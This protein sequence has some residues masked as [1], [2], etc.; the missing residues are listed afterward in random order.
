[1]KKMGSKIQVGGGKGTLE[2]GYLSHTLDGNMGKMFDIPLFGG[3]KA[4]VLNII[5]EKLA[6]G[7]KKYWVA[8]VNPEFVM[9]A[10]K[11]QKFGEILKQTSLNVVDGVGLVW[12]REINKKFLISNPPA[13]RAGVEFLKK[14]F[15]GIKVGREILNGK[16]K[17][18]IASGA[19][20][21]VDLVKMAAEKKLKLFF[22]GGW[23]DRAEKSADFFKSK[24]LI[25]NDQVNWSSGEPEFSNKEVIEKI[26]KF[27]PDILFV[28]YGMKKQEFWIAE[29]LKKLDI[30]LVMGIGRSFDY[31]SGELKRAPEWVRR[32]GMEWLYS[33]IKE[34]KRWKRQ[35]VLPKFV[36]KVMVK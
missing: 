29:N 16:Y 31:Y 25:S 21:M 5:G 7:T 33:L 34:P 23:E 6:S 11:D 10:L 1:M 14:L 28:A 9:E 30:G 4:R 3:D 15:F 22:L 17:D 35:L 32:M 18:Q 20:L 36:W 13:G 8:T 2:V 26:N 27:K 12:A 19:D 24:F